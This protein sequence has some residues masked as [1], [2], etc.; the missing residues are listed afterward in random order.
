ML[1]RVLMIGNLTRDPVLRFSK[2]NMPICHMG[3]AVNTYTRRQGAENNQETCFVDVVVFGKTAENCA[4]YLKKGRRIFVEG[5]LTFSRFTG[6]DGVQRSKHEII[7]AAVHFL[8]RGQGGGGSGSQQPQETTTEPEP[9]AEQ[10]V[11]EEPP[12]EESGGGT[13]EPPF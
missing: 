8:D 6:K 12:V 9:G 2:T 11:N 4:N 13:E 7:A 3:L 5:R 1:N 10:P